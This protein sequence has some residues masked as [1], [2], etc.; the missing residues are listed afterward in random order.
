MNEV[1][2]VAGKRNGLLLVPRR[3]LRVPSLGRGCRLDVARQ[4]A[5]LPAHTAAASFESHAKNA[6]D[7]NLGHELI[8]HLLLTVSLMYFSC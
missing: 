3:A 2:A 5:I 4:G 8:T 1:T 6:N 7:R